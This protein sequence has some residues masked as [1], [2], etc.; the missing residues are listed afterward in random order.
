MPLQ[1]EELKSFLEFKQEKIKSLSELEANRLEDL[2]DARSTI[3]KYALPATII[4]GVGGVIG[5]LITDSILMLLPVGLFLILVFFL[6][7]ILDQEKH[8]ERVMIMEYT[9]TS[10]FEVRLQEIALLKGAEN[11]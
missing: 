2:K 7:R 11:G 3:F 8:A 5:T 6:A 4:D 1:P 10:L 9:E